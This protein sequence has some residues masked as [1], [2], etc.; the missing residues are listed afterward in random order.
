MITLTQSAAAKVQQLL[1]TNT[2]QDDALP[3]RVTGGG[4][5]AFGTNSHSMARP[6][7]PTRRSNNW[8][9]ASS[10][11]RRALCISLTPHWTTWT[12]CTRAASRS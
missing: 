5:S 11:T 3:V 8:A 9:C 2:Q 12:D 7:T 6:R 1:E 10:L 4:C